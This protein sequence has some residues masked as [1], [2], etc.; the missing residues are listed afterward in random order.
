MRDTG[1]SAPAM[2]AA[3]TGRCTTPMEPHADLKVAY[4]YHVRIVRMRRAC[5]AGI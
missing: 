2:P 1:V 4:R 3:E 5:I